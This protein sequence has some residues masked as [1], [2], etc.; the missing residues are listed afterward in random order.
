LQQVVRVGTG[1][2][3]AIGRP[4]AG[5]T[6]TTNENRSAWFVGY[7]PDLST[8]IMMVKDDENGNPIT[9]RGTGGRASVTGGSFPAA[10]FA[11]YM[12]AA[13]ADVE[14][15]GFVKPVDVPTA[16]PTPVESDTPTPVPTVTVTETQEPDTTA[17]PISPTPGPTGAVPGTTSSPSPTG[18]APGR[19]R[20]DEDSGGDG[21]GGG[22]GGPGN[23]RSKDGQP[24]GQNR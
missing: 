13:L 21:S 15:R 10:I 2:S 16:T 6:G 22:S 9:L 5:K 17:S 23:G 20:D 7:T 1:R 4:V 14:P 19:E 3:A 12:R 18:F 24:P 11:Q 8:A